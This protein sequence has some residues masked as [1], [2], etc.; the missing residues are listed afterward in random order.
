M[1]ASDDAIVPQMRSMGRGSDDESHDLVEHK[2]SSSAV[3]ANK[4]KAASTSRRSTEKI[5]EEKR[6]KRL[7]R[8]RVS[9]QQARERKKHYVSNLEVR[10]KELEA[11][12]ARLEQQV[13]MLQR[14]NQMLRQIVKNSQRSL[15]LLQPEETEHCPFV[16]ER[17]VAPG[18]VPSGL[19]VIDVVC[20]PP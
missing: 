7:L 19:V 12:N 20:C 2:K 9:A 17:P 16:L 18:Y 10:S 15:Y 4:R 8:N 1:G 6:M 14:E 5:Q 13:T 3:P 11:Q